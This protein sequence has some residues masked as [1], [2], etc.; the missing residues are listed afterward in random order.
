MA[1][2]LAGAAWKFQQKLPPPLAG[3][4][5]AAADPGNAPQSVLPFQIPS[6]SDAPVFKEENAS[7]AEEAA[8]ALAPPNSLD[9]A[10]EPL[11]D[12]LEK[13]GFPRGDMEELFRRLGPSSYSPAFMAAKIAEL[14][15]LG[16]VPID[17]WADSPVAPAGFEQPV[18][19]VT[20]GEY[21][22]F[23]ARYAEE[24]KDIQKK[25]GVPGTV[26][27]AILLVET[28]LGTDL[29]KSPALRSLG[30]MAATTYPALLE[31]SGHGRLVKTV[32]PASLAASLRAKSDWAFA[33]LAALI[34]YGR[35]NSLDVSSL[36]ASRYGAL[37]LC[38]FM[39]SN[40]AAYALDGDGDGAVNLFSAV[41]ALY[42]AA[43][44]LEAH[45]WRKAG[46][47]AGRFAVLRT[48]NQDNIYAAR[49]LGVA[50]QLELADRGKIPAR[51]N[52]LSAG[53]AS[54]SPDPGLSRAGRVPAYARLRSLG[55]YLEVLQ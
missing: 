43:N 31:S 44:Y 45:G 10:W 2:V 17:T 8:C 46:T 13:E 50:R 23:T 12:R 41:D 25:H 47:E 36:P 11:L 19:D 37:G 30:S 15:G 14:Y 51:R 1:L 22:K 5:P 40:I 7:P 53:S 21:R 28:G 32:K 29:G 48:Y 35:E 6:A 49:V 52:P 54:A 34:R 24:L 18:S 38:Q 33:E 26:A 9:P 42:S 3:P 4:A 16:G 39:P 20:V 55:S 27:T